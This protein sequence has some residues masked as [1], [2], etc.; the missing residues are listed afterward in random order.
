MKDTRSVVCTLCPTQGSVVSSPQHTTWICSRWSSTSSRLRVAMM[1]SFNI[2]S[3][4]AACA[5][6][7]HAHPL[8]RTLVHTVSDLSYI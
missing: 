6:P 3:R 7:P 1:E 5:R 2:W 4:S 8:S